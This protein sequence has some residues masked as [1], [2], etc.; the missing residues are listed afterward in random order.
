MNKNKDDILEVF[1]G[2]ID[3]NFDYEKK[4]SITQ[5]LVLYIIEVF[6]DD[7]AID[8][9]QDVID[10]S[11]KRGITIAT[12]LSSIIVMYEVGQ[13]YNSS[14]I[15]YIKGSRSYKMVILQ[16]ICKIGNYG[17]TSIKNYGPYI[18]NITNNINYLYHLKF[19]DIEIRPKIDQT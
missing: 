1:G 12:I 19:G 17:G 14:I 3:Q 6:D 13:E 18:K 11:A 10:Y 5:N 4:T 2:Y 7:L 16:S 9:I 15:E 8:K